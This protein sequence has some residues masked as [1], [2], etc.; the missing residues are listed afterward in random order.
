MKEKFLQFF[1]G[2]I[3][4]SVYIAAAS[5]AVCAVT[6]IGS[7]VAVH[8]HNQKIDAVLESLA[9]A[10]SI[11]ETVTESAAESVSASGEVN[12]QQNANGEPAGDKALQ[13]IAEY[14]KLTAEYQAKR[15]ELEKQVYKVPIRAITTSAISSRPVRPIWNGRPNDTPEDISREQAEADA[16]YEIEL[17]E[18]ENASRTADEKYKSEQESIN[19]A[20]A[21]EKAKVDEAQRQIDALDAQYEKDVA[22]L[23]ERYGI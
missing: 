15:A 11:T 22:A 19:N 14:D 1:T 13:Y 4:K 21:S 2:K 6:V 12:T 9:Q 10:E 17:K 18:W 3:G 16:R 7:T 20:Y 23:K 5:A 8:N